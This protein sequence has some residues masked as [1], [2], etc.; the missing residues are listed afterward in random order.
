MPGLIRNRS[1]LPGALF[2][3]LL[4]GA[5]APA[6]AQP[7][8]VEGL[9]I[10]GHYRVGENVRSL[11]AAVP[12]NDLDL[13]TIA[14]R[15]VLRQRVRATASDL[16]DRLGESRSSVSAAPSCEQDAWNNA[17]DQIR[18]AIAEQRMPSYVYIAPD[19]PYVALA[20]P[21]AENAT[22]YAAPAAATVPPAPTYTIRTVTN[23][24]VPDTPDNRARYGGPMSQGGRATAPA[25]N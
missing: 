4:A 16:C 3:T 22:G 15:D 23:G 9:T 13:N 21:T 12:Y 2:A 7:T 11:S 20:G 1:A 10:T 19:E 25:G 24:S 18:V 14:G 6:F 5:A 8:M 17:R